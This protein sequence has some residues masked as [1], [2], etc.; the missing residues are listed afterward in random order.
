[1]IKV[2][3]LP[4]GLSPFLANVHKR[5]GAVLNQKQIQRDNNIT[6]ILIRS[7]KIWVKNAERC[8]V[9][10]QPHFG[11]VRWDFL[12]CVPLKKSNYDQQ[13]VNIAV[14]KHESQY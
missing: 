3:T 12:H 13:R 2:R 1:M 14:Y 9:R 8:R 10:L 5:T 4:T 7:K 6:F 11:T